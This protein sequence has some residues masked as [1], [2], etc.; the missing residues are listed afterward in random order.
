MLNSRLDQ[1]KNSKFTE[2]PNSQIASKC[3]HFFSQ[4]AFY[5]KFM[6]LVSKLICNN[7]FNKI[8]FLIYN[9]FNAILSLI[10]AWCL[11]NFENLQCGNCWKIALKTRRYLFKI[12]SY[13]YFE[14]L[15]LIQGFISI[16]NKCYH[17]DV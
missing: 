17:Y 1:D 13:Y 16:Y 6:I 14:I 10:S 3:D 8:R 9:H 12:N 7:G 11:F 4:E 15:K 5:L 2:N